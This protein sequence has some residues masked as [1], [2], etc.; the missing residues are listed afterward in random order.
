ML[1]KTIFITEMKSNFKKYLIEG[2][3]IVFSV[4]FALFINKLFDDYQT[5]KKK[6]VA[7][8]SIERELHRNAAILSDWKKQHIEIRNRISDILEG[9]NDSLKTELLKYS[10]LNLGVLTDNKSLIDAIL[11]NTAWESSKTTGIISEFDFETT[12][13]LTR[14]YTMQNVLTDRTIAKILDYYFDTDSHNIKNLDQILIQFQLRFWELTGQEELMVNL[15]KE[16][17]AT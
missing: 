4:L 16:A 13:K 15:Y 17:L 9:R 1:V 12:Q 6:N 14:V 11:I 3:L 2:A 8:E 7:L 5:R 10:F